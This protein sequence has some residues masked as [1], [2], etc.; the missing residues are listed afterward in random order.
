MMQ[1]VSKERYINSI[2]NGEKA[3]LIYVDNESNVWLQ[4]DMEIGGNS[5]QYRVELMD[6]E[7]NPQEGILLTTVE[8]RGF[9]CGGIRFIEYEK[10]TESTYTH[11]LADFLNLQDNAEYLLCEDTDLSSISKTKTDQYYYIYVL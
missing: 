2:T 3:F 4:A 10:N 1:F 7:L 11:A 8:C 5:E 9:H 6:F